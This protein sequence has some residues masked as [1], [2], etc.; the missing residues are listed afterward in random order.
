MAEVGGE[1]EEVAFLQKYYH[2]LVKCIQPSSFYSWLRS[3]NVLTV[4]EQEEIE[5]KYQIR[6][7]RAGSLIDTICRK[8]KSGYIAFMECVEYLYPD[9]FQDLTGNEPRL[10]PKSFEG[11][12]GRS[13]RRNTNRT[14]STEV[15]IMMS[16]VM[17]KLTQEVCEKKT[18][19]LELQELMNGVKE[20][21]EIE[22][23][24]KSSLYVELDITREK[25]EELKLDNE[26]LRKKLDE[27]T[28]ERDAL[29]IRC[30]EMREKRDESIEQCN[31]LR[32]KMEKM[33][34]KMEELNGAVRRE[35][36]LP[37]RQDQVEKLKKANAELKKE[38]DVQT[39]KILAETPNKSPHAE[40]AELRSQFAELEKKVEALTGENEVLSERCGGLDDM[41][42]MLQENNT[43]KQNSIRHFTAERDQYLRLYEESEKNLSR[44]KRLNEDLSSQCRT[45][46]DR[47]CTLTEKIQDLD[48]EI[49]ILKDEMPRPTKKSLTTC[50]RP[51]DRSED[52][53]AEN[54][55]F[56]T[57]RAGHTSP[58]LRPDNNESLRVKDLKRRMGSYETLGLTEPLVVFAPK[59]IEQVLFQELKNHFDICGYETCP[60]DSPEASHVTECPDVVYFKKSATSYSFIRKAQL[61]RRERNT[62]LMSMPVHC[63]RMM[64]EQL[65]LDPIVVII[66]FK[67]KDAIPE[68]TPEEETLNKPPAIKFVLIMVDVALKNN[69]SSSAAGAIIADLKDTVRRENSLR[70]VSSSES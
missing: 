25:N 11:V 42:T 66:K 50:R 10:P 30:Q 52:D 27:M 36:S 39:S 16:N 1:V 14:R 4:D 15:M 22:E 12:P 3:K 46:L 5:N 20:E 47:I 43:E 23:N 44:S 35:R 49:A 37:S 38:L 19:L 61:R 63:V 69:F 21:R 58:P 55:V 31:Q 53:S 33:G 32:E 68:Y 62:V 48:N 26:E 18:K 57:E 65:K 45:Y 7:L 29:Q 6:S 13:I 17:Q 41:C 60:T 2:H 70:G 67:S 40:L 8:G 54:N 28:G 9:L 34:C 56:T 51:F 59:E 64:K 24:E